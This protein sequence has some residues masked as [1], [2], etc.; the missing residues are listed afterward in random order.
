MLLNNDNNTRSRFKEDK[1]WDK[2]T[3]SC[4]NPLKR[5]DKYETVKDDKYVAVNS[6]N[7]KEKKLIENAL[8]IIQMRKKN[9]DLV[10][11]N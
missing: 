2:G 1:I 4:R 7:N 10:G 9:K 8:E 11:K 5:F 6:F 3:S